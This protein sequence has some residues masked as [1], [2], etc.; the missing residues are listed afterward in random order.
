MTNSTE[1]AKYPETMVVRNGIRSRDRSRDKA[2]NRRDDY[3]TEQAHHKLDSIPVSETVDSLDSVSTHGAGNTDLNKRACLFLSGVPQQRMV[4][5]VLWL[6]CVSGGNPKQSLERPLHLAS[7]FGE[8]SSIC[9]WDMA[10]SR[11]LHLHNF[12]GSTAGINLNE[13]PR[14]QRSPCKPKP[15]PCRLTPA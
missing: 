11:T 12:R 3:F 10:T 15:F 6:P 4:P 7:T 8:A 9:E 14:P 5:D 2:G 13:F 1:A